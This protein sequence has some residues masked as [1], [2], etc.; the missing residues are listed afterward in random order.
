MVPRTD[1]VA[2]DVSHISGLG[3]KRYYA[4]VDLKGM[5]E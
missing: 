1:K 5:P 3:P 2:I 4:P